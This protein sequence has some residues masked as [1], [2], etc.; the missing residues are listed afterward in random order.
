MKDADV[1]AQKANNK[2]EDLAGELATKVIP[3]DWPAKG[4][5]HACCSLG[6]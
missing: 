4:A 2:M 3:R 6:C 5:I 1:V